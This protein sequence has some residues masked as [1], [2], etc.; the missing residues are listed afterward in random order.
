[1]TVNKDGDGNIMEIVQWHFQYV[2]FFICCFICV[3]YHFN[4]ARTLLSVHM[5]VIGQLSKC[6]SLNKYSFEGQRQV[7]LIPIT[8]YTSRSISWQFVGSGNTLYYCLFTLSCL[9]FLY[10]HKYLIHLINGFLL[11]SRSKHNQRL[12]VS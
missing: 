7:L 3:L 6:H 8:F 2:C 4:Q 5:P 11:Y 10:F 1:M 12:N 9:F